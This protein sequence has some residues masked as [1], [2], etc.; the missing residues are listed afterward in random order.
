M[1]KFQS[2]VLFIHFANEK[3]GTVLFF[4]KGCSININVVV[5]V[6]FGKTCPSLW[7]ALAA[8]VNSGVSE[9]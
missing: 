4:L 9:V 7:I 3:I 1:K 5:A 8:I 6:P 2:V